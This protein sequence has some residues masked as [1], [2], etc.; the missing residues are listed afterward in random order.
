VK[1]IRAANAVTAASCLAGFGILAAASPAQDA[2][3]LRYE[4]KQDLERVIVWQLGDE[5]MGGRFDSAGNLIPFELP[6][7]RPYYSG[8]HPYQANRPRGHDR[9]SD[10]EKETVYEFRSSFLIPGTLVRSGSFIPQDNRVQG[11]QKPRSLAAHL[12]LAGLFREDR[13]RES[14]EAD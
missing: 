3:S 5:H 6:N 7:K 14:H 12:Q 9:I 13:K 10:A 11:L 4:F 8:L 2:N 1:T